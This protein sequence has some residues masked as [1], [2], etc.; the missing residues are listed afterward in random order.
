M[1]YLV[2]VKMREDVGFPP[3]ALIEAMNADLEEAVASGQIV[4]RGGLGNASKSTEI[5]LRG[6]EI[7]VTDG[8]WTEATE[9]AGGY[10][11][12][13]VRSHE[14]AVESARR[15][16]EISKEHWPGWEGSVEIRPITGG[17]ED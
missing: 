7:T 15:V 11:I 4:D 2:F 8:P 5:S 10:S 12:L 6:G 3:P 9:V 1:R 14:E 17:P 16:I 13:E